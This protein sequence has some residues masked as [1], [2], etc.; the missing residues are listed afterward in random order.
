MKTKILIL[1][2]FLF[3]T[4]FNTTAQ[5]K[6]TLDS[7]SELKINGKSTVSDWSVTASEPAGQLQIP[8]GFKPKVGASI[9]SN[10]SFS[11][12]VEKME[13]GRGPIMNSKIKSALKS[14]ANPSVQFNGTSS[15]ITSIKDNLMV[16]EIQGTIN[17][18]G[19]KQ[20]LVVVTNCN[21]KSGAQ[22]FTLEGNKDVTMSMFQ[23]E[24]PTAFFGK[25]QTMDL[26]NVVFKFNFIKN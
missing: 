17:V 6:F 5:S 16:V 4:Q 3:L 26:L 9:I 23:I 8:K 14:D 7:K 15:K 25:L 18:A 1:V 20:N 22:S 13:S 24:K 10:L 19:V 12:L 21:Y 2:A 11:L